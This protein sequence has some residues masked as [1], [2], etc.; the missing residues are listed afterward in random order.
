MNSRFPSLLAGPVEL[1]DASIDPIRLVPT[2]ALA[3]ALASLIRTSLLAFAVL[4]TVPHHIC[5]TIS[6]VSSEMFLDR[7]DKRPRAS[8]G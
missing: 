2:Q 4:T 8:R 6:V 5:V 7:F 3:Y 1:S